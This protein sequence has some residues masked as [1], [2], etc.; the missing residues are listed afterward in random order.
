MNV[1]EQRVWED[2]SAS[3]DVSGTGNYCLSHALSEERTTQSN[4][5]HRFQPVQLFDE[6]SVDDKYIVDFDDGGSRLAKCTEYSMK[7]EHKE[8]GEASV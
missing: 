3:F 7:R 4:G 2:A 8:T 1:S 6:G 5:N